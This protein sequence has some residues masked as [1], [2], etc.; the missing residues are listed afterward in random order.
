MFNL[1]RLFFK[2]LAVFCCI[3]STYAASED[4]WTV[5]I[6]PYLWA[7]NMNGTV[8]TGGNRL[9]INEN[10]ND[11]L[12]QLNWAGM[13]WVDARKDKWD[14]FLN[15]LY[16]SLSNTVH[17]G[18]TSLDANNYYSI[19]SVGASYEIYKKFFSN[20]SLVTLEPYL[21]ARYTLNNTTLTLSSPLFTIRAADDQHW[22]DPILGLRVNYWMT[23][24]WKIILAGDIGGTNARTHYSYNV[25]GLL[26]YKPQKWS[27][28]TLY[29]GY[30]LL[31]QH[32]ETGNGPTFYNWNMK[33]FGPLIGIAITV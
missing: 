24:A 12:S 14:I 18:N 22:T 20:S 29:L 17:D 28:T 23:K 27:N 16:A 4:H 7:I 5:E 21:G 26:G 30:R 32:Y 15:T 19:V 2:L 1:K 13:V 33:N 8:Q 9:H 6:A 11:V 25:L 10:F 3:S 31:D